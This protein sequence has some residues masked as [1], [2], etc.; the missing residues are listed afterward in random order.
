M[1]DPNGQESSPE[2]SGRTLGQR[3]IRGFRLAFFLFPILDATDEH[4]FIYFR[5]AASRLLGTMGGMS[6][7]KDPDVIALREELKRTLER[8]GKNHDGVTL[9]ECWMV[10]ARIRLEILGRLDESQWQAAWTELALHE[11]KVLGPSRPAWL[12]MLNNAKNAIDAAPPKRTV[13]VPSLLQELFNEVEFARQYTSLRIAKYIRLTAVAWSL[14]AS[15]TLVITYFL[16]KW[17]PAGDT[18]PVVWLVLLFGLLG[19]TMS[20][21]Q[22][23]VEIVEQSR[24]GLRVGEAQIRLRPLV[25]GMSA[26]VVYAI[27]QSG[28]VFEILGGD[29][30]GVSLIQ[31]HVDPNNIPMAYYGISFA[32]GF[33]ERL[34]LGILDKIGERIA[35]E[36]GTPL[37]AQPPPAHSPPQEQASADKKKHCCELTEPAAETATETVC[38]AGATGKEGGQAV[39]SEEKK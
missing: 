24:A 33:S 37:P 3:F 20:A 6:K 26:L 1:S 28:V 21:L 17:R 27:S 9:A 13:S 38:A 12:E 23:N 34:F 10:Y 8:A 30:K 11:R 16:S 2:L 39:P 15:I 4:D 14:I 5:S 19:G 32:I 29:A 22:K 35:S 18:R 36:K 25:G 31:I 7:S